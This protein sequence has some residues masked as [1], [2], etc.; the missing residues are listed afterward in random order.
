MGEIIKKLR[1]D[2]C[3]TAMK[4]LGYQALLNPLEVGRNGSKISIYG[5]ATP[6]TYSQVRKLSMVVM[7]SLHRSMQRAQDVIVEIVFFKCKKTKI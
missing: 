1:V 4:N 6:K 3:R 5:I 2:L 7:N